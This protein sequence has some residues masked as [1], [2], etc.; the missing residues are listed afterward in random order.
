MELFLYKSI[1]IH[2]AHSIAD[3]MVSDLEK[4]K[5]STIENPNTAL[6]RKKGEV[7]WMHNINTITTLGSQSKNRNPGWIDEQTQQ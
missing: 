2:N 4:I 6:I 1:S 3:F 5:S 7:Y